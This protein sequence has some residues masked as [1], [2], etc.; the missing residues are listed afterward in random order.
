MNIKTVEDEDK[1]RVPA[2]SKTVN[3]TFLPLVENEDRYLICYGGRGSSKSTFAAKKLIKRCMTEKY[4][5]YILYRRTFNTIRD[6]QYQTIK[7][8]VEEWGLQDVFTFALSP[9][10]IRCVNG[11][12]FICRGG[13]EPKKLKSI[14]DPTGVWY[15]E[16]IPEEGDFITITTSIRTD[17]APYLQEIM[18]INPEVEGDYMQHWFWKRFFNPDSNRD[19]AELSFSDTTTVTLADGR[20]FTT[21]YTCHHSTY[22]DNRWLPDSFKAQLLELKKT[23]PYYYTIYTLGCWGNKTT[24]GNFYK[25]FDRIRN[26][27]PE[28]EC[29]YNPFLPLHLTFDFNVHPYIT[30]CIWQVTGKNAVQIDEICAATP[31]NRTDKV[32]ERF[33]MQYSGHKA[34]VFIYGDPAGVHEDTRTELGY[35]DYRIITRTLAQYKPVARWQK[36]APPVHIRGMFINAIFESNFKDISLTISERCTNTIADYMMLK[37]ASDG[38]KEK[39]REKHPQTGV[40]YEKY[41]HTSDAN[42]YFICSIFREE[43]RVYQFGERKSQPRYMQPRCRR[44]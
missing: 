2:M 3:E 40:S 23:N 29:L 4:F 24:D 42:D 36:V 12:K 27:R 33:M 39:T 28:A 8:V 10:E 5:R 19:R 13:D 37:E 16:E 35:N 31:H 1:V 41:G 15:E 6:S 21:S 11:N 17:K 44:W 30:M 34:G 38:R 26:T 43:F 20:K 22:L 25:L 9:L 7:D 18:T 32:C 14:K